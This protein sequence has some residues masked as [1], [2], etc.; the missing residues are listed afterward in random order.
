[1][2]CPSF[3]PAG[4]R[5]FTSRR[6]RSTPGRS[7]LLALVRDDLTAAA[8]GRAHLRERER[9]LVDRD[10]ARAA[11]RRAHLGERAGLGA[12]AAAHR[13]RRV[14]RERDR[15]RDAVDRV[16]E[17]E[18]QL[19]LEVL[20]AHR[21]DRPGAAAATA[22]TEAATRATAAEQVAEQVA[23]AAAVVEVELRALEARDRSRRSRPA[24]PPLATISRT[25]SYS[26][27][28]SGSPSTSCAADTSLKRSSAAA[29]PAFASG[30]YCLAS[31]R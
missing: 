11:A 30:W 31:F 16:E 3:T 12:R 2:R 19:G 28:F 21:A 1:M 7:A 10:R 27:R 15:R 24:P 6:R 8:A 9:A 25:W 18:V 22:P 23:E 13:A 4:M 29:S 20:A 17:V 26:L 14:G 5:T